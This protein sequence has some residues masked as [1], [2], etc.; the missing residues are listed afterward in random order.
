MITDYR[1]DLDF[2]NPFSHLKLGKKHPTKNSMGVTFTRTV[3]ANTSSKEER[4]MSE[5]TMECSTHSQKQ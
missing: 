4:T 1:E 3:K 5:P 2:N